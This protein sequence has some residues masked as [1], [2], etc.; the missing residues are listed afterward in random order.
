[1]NLNV[2]VGWLV[3]A[4]VAQHHPGDKPAPRHIVNLDL[5][6]RQRWQKIIP[7]YKEELGA[8]L[9]W[10]NKEIAPLAKYSARLQNATK[11]PQEYVEEIRGAAESVGFNFSEVYQAQ[12]LYELQH[13]NTQK[14]CTSIIAEKSNGTIMHVRNQDLSYP[15]LDKVTIDVEF[16]KGGKTIYYGTTFAGYVGVPTGM[17]ATG[18]SVAAHTRFELHSQDECIA[19]AEKGGQVIGQV[20]RSV[21]ESTPDFATGTHLL[22]TNEFIISCYLICAGVKH[23]EGKVI[24]RE[25]DNARDVWQLTDNRWFEVETNWDHWS[26]PFDG[27]RKFANDQMN[28]TTAE[29]VDMDYMYKIVSTKPDYAGDTVYTSKMVPSLGYYESVVRGH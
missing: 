28:K 13:G 15:G 16:Q 27:R 14:A 1:M 19:A 11:M 2:V 7:Q 29:K 8:I 21:L 20:I 22:E 24:T 4:V 12:F 10:I 25:M 3:V 6:P 23:N 5:P 17:T 9:T 26:I 18:Y